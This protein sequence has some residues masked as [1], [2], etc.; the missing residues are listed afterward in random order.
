MASFKLNIAQIRGCP[1]SQELSD[2]LE[3][4]ALPDTEEFGV[5]NHSSSAGAVHA[6]IIRKTHQAVQRFDPETREVSAVPIERAVAYPFTVSPAR[7]VLEV[8]AGPAGAIAQIGTFFSSCLA[9]PTIVDPIKLDVLSAIDKLDKLTERFQL[10]GIRITDYAHNSFMAGPYSPK[11][12]DTLHGRDF[13]EEYA[14]YITSASVRF[15]GPTGRI[16]VTLNPK[17][18]FTYS[19]SEDDQSTAQAILRKLI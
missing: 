5:L 13:A 1:S 3:E 16:N 7:E 10:R 8:Y 2:A 12:L 19:C 18:S 4:F 9:L 14:D 11:F 17:A 15:A 6:T